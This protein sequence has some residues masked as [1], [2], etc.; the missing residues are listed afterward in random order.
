MF[1]AL[2]GYDLEVSAD[3]AVELMIGIAASELVEAQ[4]AAWLTQRIQP[5]A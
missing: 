5:H 1:C 4:V 3:D 2:N